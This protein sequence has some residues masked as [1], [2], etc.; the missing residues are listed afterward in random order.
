MIGPL[1]GE[2]GIVNEGF[3]IA[4]RVLGWM[5]RPTF[6]IGLK[7]VVAVVQLEL[8][9]R[10]A[11]D[12]NVDV[13]FAPVLRPGAPLTARRLKSGHVD[14][15]RAALRAYGAARPEHHAAETPP[16]VQHA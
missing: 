5:L 2:S 14:S 3:A 8:G 7:G 10:N 1:F 4:G 9:A 12:A 6:G 15:Q 13:H 16:A 11:G